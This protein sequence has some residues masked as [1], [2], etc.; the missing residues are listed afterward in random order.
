MGAFMEEE[1][2]EDDGE[3]GL[4]RLDGVREGDGHEAEGEVGEGVGEDVYDGERRD[5]T[6]DV[7]AHDD[8]AARR[9]EPREAEHAA[10]EELH[11]RRCDGLEPDLEQ[12]LVVDVEE[13]GEGVPARQ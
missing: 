3:E 6:Q 8:G 5:G 12:L 7:G 11:G 4:H 9:G 10:H 13:D 1:H 2:G